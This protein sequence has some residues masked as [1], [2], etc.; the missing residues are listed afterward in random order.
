MKQFGRN[1]CRRNK[2]FKKIGN[3][4]EKAVGTNPKIACDSSTIDNV[5]TTG[6]F[7]SATSDKDLNPDDDISLQ[8]DEDENFEEIFDN[9][10][11]GRN[12][13][14]RTAVNYGNCSVVPVKNHTKWYEICMDYQ[15]NDD[16]EGEIS[17]VK[18]QIVKLISDVSEGFTLIADES[19]ETG[20]IPRS[21][22]MRFPMTA[23]ELDKKRQ[24][25]VSVGGEENNTNRK[26]QASLF[27]NS[28]SRRVSFKRQISLTNTMSTLASPDSGS[29]S[30]GNRDSK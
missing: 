10:N 4:L 30:F 21:C 16:K 14:Y 5:S 17:V 25:F 27:E 13:S 2:S 9:K 15:G 1:I 12:E 26:R 18:G 22:L 24:P 28:V 7:L 11:L 29:F 6:S 19:G 3:L 8:N 23:F 20:K